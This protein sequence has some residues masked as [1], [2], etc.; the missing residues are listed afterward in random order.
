[1][2]YGVVYSTN[3][4][5]IRRINVPDRAGDELL[6]VLLLPGEAAVVMAPADEPSLQATLSAQIGKTP[7][8]DRYAFV[9]AG[10][11]VLVPFTIVDVHIM[12]PLIDHVPNGMQAIAHPTVGPGYTYTT[13]G[14][15]VP[16][17]SA[18]K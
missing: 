3:T 13:A 10:A 14:G 6:G 1:M 18:V 9:P 17:A 11:A 7:S 4:G 15:L 16:S 5:R 8:N 2:A 12:D